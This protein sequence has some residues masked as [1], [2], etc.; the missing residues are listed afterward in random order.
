MAEH[1]GPP[2]PTGP[3]MSREIVILTQAADDLE[4]GMDFYENTEPGAG[5][6]FRDSL[7]ADLRRIAL[8]PGLHALHY[9]FHRSL[10][11]RFPYAIYYRDEG[12]KRLVVAVLDLR[13]DPTWIRKRLAAR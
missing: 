3:E 12:Y 7:L 13:R 6:Y 9:G 10:A 5:A 2:A 11:A 1:G 8:F 4:A